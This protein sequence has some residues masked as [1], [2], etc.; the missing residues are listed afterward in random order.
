MLPIVEIRINNMCE[1]ST[2]LF[3]LLNNEKNW[4]IQIKLSISMQ[5]LIEQHRVRS[6]SLSNSSK[7]A[8]FTRLFKS[9]KWR[10]VTE[11]KGL[12]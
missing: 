5:H 3:L 2:N 6:C 7:C 12:S 1:M 9:L 11:F 4:V 8:S 10:A